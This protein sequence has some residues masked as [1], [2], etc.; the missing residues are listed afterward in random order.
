AR[1]QEIFNTKPIVL[2]GV[3]GLN[4]QTF[5]SGVTLPASFTG[6]CTTCHDAP[7]VGDHSVK[8]P[9]NIGLTDASRRTPDMPLYTLRRLSNGDGVQTMDPG[10][11][12]ITGK[13]AD[14]GKFK[15]PVLRALASRAPYFHNG[16]AG[17]LEAVVEFYDSRFGIGFTAQEKADLVAFLRAL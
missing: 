10:R 1:G 6:T 9:L 16:F 14:I 4:G 11:A 7:N 12:M 13:W 17:S 15:G 5:S 2:S 8:A 3:G